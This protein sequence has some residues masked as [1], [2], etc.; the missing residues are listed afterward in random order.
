MSR[1]R[2]TLSAF[3]LVASL[4]GAACGTP[5]DKEL[6]Q[7]QAAI[8][9]A[10]AAG[11]DR[12]AVEEFTA[13]QAAL[14]RATD[15]VAQRDYR[16]ALNNALD[17]RE[18]AQTATREATGRMAAARRDADRALTDVAAAVADA[19]TKLKA[20][21]TARVPGATLTNA[22]SAIARA[23]TAVQEARSALGR[24]DYKAATDAAAKTTATLR[25]ISRD[26]Q[27]AASVPAHRRRPAPGRS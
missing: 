24:G 4:I 26:L 3:A 6:Q 25:Q 5:P 14:A 16:L 18:R 13:A 22:R 15:A 1:P 23:E 17:A 27:T 2:R 19:R 21:E 10:R 9:A 11:A 7:A 12:F 20:A 8:D